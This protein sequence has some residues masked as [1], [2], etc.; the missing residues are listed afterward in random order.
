MPIGGL[1]AIG[2]GPAVVVAAV[3]LGVFC[4]AITFHLTYRII[5]DE[6]ATDA[7]VV[8]YL[9]PVVSVLLGAVVLGED[10]SVR[11]V[12]GMAV[13]V[14]VGMTRR[15]GATAEPVAAAGEPAVAE[16]ATPGPAADLRPVG[17]GPAVEDRPAEAPLLPAGAAAPRRGRHGHQALDAAAARTC[18]TEARRSAES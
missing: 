14:G 1:D 12:L 11:V 4:T 18:P 3:V 5:N 8:G 9:L 7:A 2:P 6:G 10:L 17:S 15:Q 13:V 16:S